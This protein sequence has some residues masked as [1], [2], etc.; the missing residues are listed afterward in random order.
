MS[1]W[2]RHARIVNLV[3]TSIVIFIFFVY[4]KVTKALLAAFDVYRK[5]MA[6]GAYYMRQDLSQE[7]FTSEHVSAMAV[8]GVGLCA[9]TLGVPVTAIFIIRRNRARLY[10]SR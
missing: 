4:L 6:N 7:A 10:Q 8:A 9:W 2:E 1:F 3:L 5:P